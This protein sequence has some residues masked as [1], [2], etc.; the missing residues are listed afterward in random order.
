[1]KI[2][3]QEFYPQINDEM[4]LRRKL[5]CVTKTHVYNFLDNRVALRHKTNSPSILRAISRN[6]EATPN[7]LYVPGPK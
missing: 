5:K 1:M 7:R 6:R 4:K 2:Q 3:F